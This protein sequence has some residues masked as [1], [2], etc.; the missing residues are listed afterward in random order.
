VEAE[1]NRYPD[2]PNLSN[3]QNV[4][5]QR[6]VCLVVGLSTIQGA[7]N[8]TYHAIVHNIIGSIKKGS[9]RSTRKPGFGGG[10]L[11]QGLL[12]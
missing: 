9:L 6:L 10:I 7:V 3:S 5:L 11:Q 12:N 2:S 8:L 1:P 4:I